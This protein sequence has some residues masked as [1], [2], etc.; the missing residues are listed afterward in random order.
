MFT[1]IIP[2][3]WR[4]EYTP[5]L[6]NDLN[7]CPEVGEIILIENTPGGENKVVGKTRY[8][9]QGRNIYVNPAWNWGVREAKYENICICNDDVNF[10]TSVFISPYIRVQG[11]V[12][13]ASDNYYVE[14]DLSLETFDKRP[15]GWGCLIFTKIYRLD[16]DDLLAPNALKNVEKYYQNKG[17]DIYRSRSMYYFCDNKYQGI[18]QNVNT[19]NAFT[20]EFIS[21]I[22]FPDVS[23]VEDVKLIYESGGRIYEGEELTMIYR[24]GSFTYHI[25]ALGVHNAHN[26]ELLKVGIELSTVEEKGHIILNPSFMNDYWGVLN[27]SNE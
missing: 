23:I 18:S 15:W 12:G 10:S 17:Y 27:I 19:G 21:R 11:V 8:M 26:E 9:S 7:N 25:S 5:K 22:E 16:D 3:M 6:L 14:S 13:M 20:K 4:S 24:W 1:V 2:T